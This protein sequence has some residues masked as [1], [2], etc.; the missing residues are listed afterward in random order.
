MGFSPDWLAL[1]E[2]VDHASRDASRLAQAVACAGPG[3]TVVDLGSGTGSTARAFGETGCTW[4]F[5]DGDQALLD[6]AQQRHPGAEQ[7]VFDL[8]HI[9]ELPLDGVRLVTASALLDLMPREWVTALARRLQAAGIPF[10]GALNY[11]GVMRWSPEH[12]A[13]AGVTE[14][15]NAHQLTDKGIGPALGPTSAD[16]TADIFAKHG[17]DVHLG[18]SPWQLNGS[19]AQ[20]HDELLVGIGNAAAEA[21]FAQAQDWV[22][23]RRATV[24]DTVGYIGHT[25]IFAVPHGMGE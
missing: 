16:V 3:T 17:F 11:N 23:D 21:G 7:L 25:D 12:T 8:R 6:I 2:P 1:R 18:D 9:D 15:F 5:V 4:R 20:L 14:A 10:Y 24:S 13:D 22:T 19:A